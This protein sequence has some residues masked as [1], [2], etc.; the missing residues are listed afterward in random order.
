MFFMKKIIIVFLGIIVI[1][2]SSC[3]TIVIML[4]NTEFVIPFING[5]NFYISELDQNLSK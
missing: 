2:S 3:I 1:L 5:T 4:E